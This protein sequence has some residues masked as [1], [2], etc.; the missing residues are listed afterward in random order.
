MIFPTIR[1]ILVSEGDADTGELIQYH[2]VRLMGM[3]RGRGN[4]R[5]IVR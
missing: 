5:W 1:A 4:E 2:D 3:E